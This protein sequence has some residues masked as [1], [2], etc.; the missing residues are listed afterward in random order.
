MSSM[1]RLILI[2]LVLLMAFAMGGCTK[3]EE[4]AAAEKVRVSA[5]KAYEKYFGPAPTTDKG[6]CFAF[7]IYFPSAKEPGKVVPFP[8]FTFDEGSIKKVAIDRLLS[9]LDVPAYK[10]ELTQ[11]V[12]T[13]ARLLGL[14]EEKGVVTVRFNRELLS[15]PTGSAE[16]RAFFNAL[17]LTL[18]Q[19]KGVG[20][21]LVAVEGKEQGMPHADRQPLVKDEKAVLAPGPPRLLEVAAVKDKGAKTFEDVQAYFDRPV[22][23]KDL[24]LSDKSGNPFAGELYRSVFDM[25]AVLKPNDPSLFSPGMPIKVRWKVVDK[26]GRTSEGSS[27][28][29]LAVKEH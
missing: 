11:P 22:E 14:T 21:V 12:P 24:V 20:Q 16:H 28:L 2:C 13:G 10:G 27:E 6:T 1:T 18:V 15:L 5:T 17:V 26:L 23:I 19:F 25:A 7:V 29:P 8:F 3:K 4:T 9:G